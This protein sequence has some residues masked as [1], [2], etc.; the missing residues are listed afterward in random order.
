M[1]AMRVLYDGWP[2]VHAPESAGT[3][4]LRTL[5]TLD[6]EGVEALLAVPG[7]LSEKLLA[8]VISFEARNRGTWEQKMLPQLAATHGVDF[9]HTTEL[10]AS[11]FGKVPTL[12]SPTNGELKQSA[13]GSRIAAAQGWGGLARATILWPDDLAAPNLPG[14][15]RKI[16]PVVN[17]QFIPQRSAAPSALDLPEEYLLYRGASDEQSLLRLLESWTWAAASVGEFYPL[18]FSGLGEEAKHFVEK[19]APDFHVQD[20]VR[21]LPVLK[22]QDTV[23]VMQNCAAFVHGGLPAPWGSALRQALACGKAVVAHR[24]AMTEAI[25]GE[26]GYLVEEEDLRSFGAAMITVVVDEKAREALEEKALKQS[27][28]W[29]ATKFKGALAEI[30]GRK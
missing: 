26:G 1:T 13:G 23:A 24:E 2:L 17:S 5:L 27:A 29:D 11:L 12:V 25:V 9:I 8:Q 14:T 18:V 20:S 6:L 4:H 7:E 19:N 21:V 28:R 15:I 30:Y 16:P 22:S 10:A 3:W